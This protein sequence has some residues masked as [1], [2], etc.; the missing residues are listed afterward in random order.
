MG[1]LPESRFH[2]AGFPREYGIASGGFGLGRRVADDFR[3]HQRRRRITPRFGGEGGGGG[4]A[5]SPS[6]SITCVGALAG[7]SASAL[8]RM[9]MW[10]L[11]WTYVTWPERIRSASNGSW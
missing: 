3:L 4:G 5:T 1:R 11:C 7:L 6:N 9:V 2:L 10:L 8:S